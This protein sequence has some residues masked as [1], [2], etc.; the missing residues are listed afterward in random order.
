MLASANVIR[1][2]HVT[3]FFSIK[4]DLTNA[5]GI[6]EDKEVVRDDNLITSRMPTDLPAFCSTLIQAMAE[7]NVGTSATA[8]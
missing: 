5:G 8:G 6:Y 7:A 4:D 2:K 1:H 3:S